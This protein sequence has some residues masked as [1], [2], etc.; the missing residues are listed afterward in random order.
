MRGSNQTGRTRLI[1][2]AHDHEHV[3]TRP[4]NMFESGVVWRDWRDR[5][6]GVEPQYF[7]HTFYRRVPTDRPTRRWSIHSCLGVT[8]SYSSIKAYHATVSRTPHTH[9][10][11]PSSFALPPLHP[12]APNF[13][14]R[15]FY[16]FFAIR[17]SCSMETFYWIDNCC[18]KLSN[19]LR[20]INRLL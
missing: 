18:Q 1:D 14:W 2:Y 19:R 15:H 8:A 4:T 10:H 9:Q 12:P 16:L 11:L 7:G 20:E 6:L 13:I 17:T 3:A 5:F